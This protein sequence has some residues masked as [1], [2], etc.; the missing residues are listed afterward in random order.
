LAIEIGNDLWKPI[1]GKRIN[2][3]I[4][5]DRKLRTASTVS[6]VGTVIKV[7]DRHRRSTGSGSHGW[8]TAPRFPHEV[9]GLAL[10][11]EED[12]SA[13]CCSVTFKRIKEAISSSAPAASCR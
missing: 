2:E 13:P 10:N 11:L 5:A 6:E 8:R 12:K 1:K 9:R 3:I 7:G 4:G